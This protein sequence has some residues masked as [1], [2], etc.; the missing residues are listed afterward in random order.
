M[1][2]CS[3]DTLLTSLDGSALLAA[4]LSFDYEDSDLDSPDLICSGGIT[5]TAAELHAGAFRVGC[6]NGAS[7]RFTLHDTD[8][9]TPAR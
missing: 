5:L 2:Q 7:A 1:E 6:S 4:P 9:G 8:R 3:N